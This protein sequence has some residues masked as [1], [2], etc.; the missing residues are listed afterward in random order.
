MF[1][2]CKGD[3]IKLPVYFRGKS[4]VGGECSEFKMCDIFLEIQ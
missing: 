3:P 4:Q 1:N 2:R